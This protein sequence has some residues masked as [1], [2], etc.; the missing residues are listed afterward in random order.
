MIK[1]IVETEPEGQESIDDNDNDGPPEDLVETIETYETPTLPYISDYEDFLIQSKTY[2]INEYQKKD[3][4]VLKIIYFDLIRTIG[5]GSFGQVVFAKFKNTSKYFAIKILSKEKIVHKQ[6]VQHVTNEKNILKSIRFPFIV[7]LEA[8]FQ[9]TTN[10]YLVFEYLN[11][12]EL[13]YH[14]RNSGPLNEN[15][16]RYYAGQICLVLEYLHYLNVIYRDLKPE[17]LVLDYDG[18]LKFVD[19]GFAKVLFLLKTL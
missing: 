8:S 7:S 16:S 17:N 12:G 6:Q 3:K 1:I 13:F 9:D 15:T 4:P 5:L 10:I 11:G 2:F 14:L 18:N 19:F